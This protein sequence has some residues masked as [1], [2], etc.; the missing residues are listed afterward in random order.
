MERP[1]PLKGSKNW[2]GRRRRETAVQIIDDAEIEK[3]LAE[4]EKEKEGDDKESK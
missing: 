3:L 1:E 4:A 2:F